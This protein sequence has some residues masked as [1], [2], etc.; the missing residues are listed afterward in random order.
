M[1]TETSYNAK[2]N[3]RVI[4]GKVEAL[5][6][7]QMDMKGHVY[8]YIRFFEKTTGKV[9]TIK[10]VFVFNNVDSYLTTDREAEFFIAKTGKYDCIYA[11]KTSDRYVED[12]DDVLNVKTKALLL[13]VMLTLVGLILS[14]ILIGLPI[15]FIGLRAIY[16]F[17]SIKS[18]FDLEEFSKAP[19]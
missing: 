19:K 3:L 10:N 4:S 14:I 17:F 8:A 13:G 7:A 6:Q 12:I 11:I 15:L 18:R 5:G 1:N 2:D 9:I 16:Y